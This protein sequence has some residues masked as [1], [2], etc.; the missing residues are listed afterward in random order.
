MIAQAERT[1][2]RVVH[3]VQ[4]IGEW[5]REHIRVVQKPEL[6]EK[7]KSINVRKL[8]RV[9]VSLRRGAG[10]SLGR[11]L[12]GLRRLGRSIARVFGF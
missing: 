7:V 5:V 11:S 6:D 1:V 10:R 8:A 9:V 4:K 12:N 2:R 3:D